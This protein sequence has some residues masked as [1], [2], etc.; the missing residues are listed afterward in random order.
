MGAVRAF[1]SPEEFARAKVRFA[2]HPGNVK[3]FLYQERSIC[4][5]CS[6]NTDLSAGE[7][8]PVPL[9]PPMIDSGLVGLLWEGCRESRRCSRD[10]YPESYIA[11]YTSIRRE[12]GTRHSAF[13]PPAPEVNDSEGFFSS[14]GF[15]LSANSRPSP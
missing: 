5:S 15:Y 3:A 7:G 6:L 2:Y 4:Q 13:A 11:K 9:N 12:N 8:S 14:H 10:T 1:E